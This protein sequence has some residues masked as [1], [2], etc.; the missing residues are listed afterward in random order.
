MKIV[1]NIKN[2]ISKIKNLVCPPATQDLELNTKNRDNAVKAEHIQYGPLNVDEPGD[3]WK[4]IADAWSTSEKAAKKSLCSNCIAFDISPRMKKCMPGETS[5]KD[6]ELGY[7][8]MHHFK[9][10]SARSCRTWAKGGPI[11]QDSKSEEW[12]NKAKLEEETRDTYGSE[13]VD[14]YEKSRKDA[15]GKIYENNKNIKKALDKKL[16]KEG[17]AAGLEP[18]V[19]AA[20]KIDPEITKDEVVDILNGMSNVD[21]HKDGDYIDTA[22]LKEAVG[23]FLEMKEEFL[24]EKKRKKKKKSK[25]KKKGKKDACY[26]KVRAR[27][28]VWPSA[29]ASGAL[30]KCRKVGAANWGTGGKKKKEESLSIEE[31]KKTDYSKEKESGLHGWFSRAG[32]KGKSKGWVDCNT[33]KTDKK[34]GKKTCKSC[35]R[36][37]GEKRSKYPAC[38][39]TPSDCGTKGKGKKW[40]KKSSK[41]E[42]VKMKIKQSE[43]KE[44]VKTEIESILVEGAIFHMEHNIPITENIYRRGTKKYF[45]LFREIRFLSRQGLYKLNE[46]EKHLIEETE[47]GEFAMFEGEMVP[48][49]FPMIDETQEQDFLEEKKKKKKKKDPPIGKPTK[50]TGGGKKYKV[51]VRGKSG[52]VKKITYGDSKGGLK[53]NWNNAEARKSFAARHNCADKKDRTKAG[54]WACRAH[55]D[56]GTNVPGRFW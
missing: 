32:G 35:G 29:Y 2:A 52:R 27:Y 33:C 55:K 37:E 56:F 36:K 39:P 10:H 9:C 22:E 40:G 38:R 44:F 14:R 11:R 20:K 53:G 26:H 42:E 24:D 25:K 1:I 21:Q 54:Y 6:G 34:T 28:D 5:D 4:D 50:N 45:K 18:L 17:G 51:Y 49:D 23:I 47:I 15:I 41:K 16:D 46:D 7:C 43:L 12:Q 31:K 3:Y 30:V 19:D 13:V 48:L 8:W